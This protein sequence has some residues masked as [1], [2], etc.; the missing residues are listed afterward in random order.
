MQVP[1]VEGLLT[2]ADVR[3]SAESIVELQLPNGMIEWYRGGHADPWNHVETAMALST[4]GFIDQAELAYGWLADVQRP[5]GSWHN[6]YTADGI[7]DSKLDS[8]C[9]AY[10]AAGVWH[11]WLATGDRKFLEEYW[12]VV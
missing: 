5:D 3:L 10:I 12:D 11:H 9:I 8:N 7:E 1:Y 4:C 2:A 6:Y